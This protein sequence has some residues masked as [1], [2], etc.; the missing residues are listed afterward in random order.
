MYALKTLQ[1]HFAS[2][3]MLRANNGQNA[4]VTAK[5]PLSE[6][7]IPCRMEGCTTRITMKHHHGTLYTE[8]H[9]TSQLCD[10]AR[11]PKPNRKCG[12]TGA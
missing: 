6:M 11:A 1:R 10:A 4:R 2:V 5:F 8:G 9:K 7:V 12:R 3:L